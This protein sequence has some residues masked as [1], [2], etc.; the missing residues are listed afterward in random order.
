MRRIRPA[1]SRASR[2]AVLSLALRFRR[3]SR[4]RAPTA[5]VARPC[6]RDPDC[7]WFSRSQR[8]LRA[9]RGHRLGRH[10]CSPCSWAPLATALAILRY[11]LYDIDLI[12]RRTLVYGTATVALAGLYL[13]IVLLFQRVFSSFAGGG[14]LAIAASTLIAFAL[15]RPVRARI[16]ALVDRRFYRRRYDAQRILEAFASHV[17]EEVDLR[18]LDRRARHHR[19]P[20]DAAGT[21][22]GLASRA[23]RRERAAADALRPQRRRHDRVPGRGRGTGRSDARAGLSVAR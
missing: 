17:R 1:C 8:S 22:L 10:A 19:R 15:F 2:P 9:G 7:A 12:I 4:N 13:A 21:R 16:Q 14:D 20:D 6:R 23:V 18:D 5:Q 3:A 11:R